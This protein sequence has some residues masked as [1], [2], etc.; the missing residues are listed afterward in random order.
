MSTHAPAA[1]VPLRAR[2]ADRAP[3]GAAAI[4]GDYLSITSYRRDGTP[5]STPVWFVTEGD[6]LLVTTDS[7][8]GKAKRI[9]R[10]PIVTIS[11]CSARGKPRGAPVAA[12]AGFL[13]AA[14]LERVKRLM[15]RKYRVALVFIRP[16][17]AL[18]RLFQPKREDEAE[19]ALSITAVPS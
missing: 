3:T 18:Q 9:R 2:R 1:G 11:A 14:E 8:S 15:A 7:R 4:T 10:N 12:R 6:R 5:V 13:P 16:I 19:V 17:R